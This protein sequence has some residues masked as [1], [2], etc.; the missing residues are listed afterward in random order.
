MIEKHEKREA[1]E[2]R[3]QKQEA[4]KP[5]QKTCKREVESI[6]EVFDADIYDAVSLKTCVEKR[7]T[8][9]APG[10]AAMKGV[11]GEY[12]KYLED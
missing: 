1:R 4:T 5:F 3:E 6:S 10:I 12:H 11:I 9:G 2:K 7:L 8:T